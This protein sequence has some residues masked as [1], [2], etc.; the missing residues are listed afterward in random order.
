MR[1]LL[2]LAVVTAVVVL[3]WGSWQAGRRP[4]YLVLAGVGVASAVMLMSFLFTDQE[5]LVPGDPASVTVTVTGVSQM[6]TGVRV[7]G[8]ISNRGEHAIAHVLLDTVALSCPPAKA[9]ETL[10][11][12]RIPV[13]IHVPAGGRYPV[14]V[15][16]DRDR[17]MRTPDRWELRVREVQVYGE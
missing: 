3:L 16:A 1:Y 7:S 4:F 6:E 9:C 17:G 11:E 2:V 10:H 15:V 12:E 13:S 5:R 8:E 14:A